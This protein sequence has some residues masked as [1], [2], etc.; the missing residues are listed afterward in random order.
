MTKVGYALSSEEH[1]PLDLV[2]NAR[3][4]D[5][6]GFAEEAGVDFLMPAVRRE[7]ARASR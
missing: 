1:A 4:A 7:P 5:E 6:A 2:R 3:L